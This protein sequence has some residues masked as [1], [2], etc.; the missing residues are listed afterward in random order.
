M[1]LRFQSMLLVSGD[2]G[3]LHGVAP[4]V[5][6]KMNLLLKRIREGDIT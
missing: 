4:Q 1:G 3:N 2:L 6:L 5:D